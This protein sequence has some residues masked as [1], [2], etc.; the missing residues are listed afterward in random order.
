M[1]CEHS[2][3]YKSDTDVSDFEQKPVENT[4]WGLVNITEVIWFGKHK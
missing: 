3:T 4:C 2:F 1:L